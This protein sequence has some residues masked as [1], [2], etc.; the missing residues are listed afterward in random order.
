LKGP[1]TLTANAKLGS[2]VHLNVTGRYDNS[3]STKVPILQLSSTDPIV[4]LIV[5]VPI[6]IFPKITIFVGASG[7]VTAGFS[8][9]VTDSA[10][11]TAGISYINGQVTPTLTATNNFRTDPFGIDGGFSVKAFGG[12]TLELD[13]DGVLSPQ[14]SPDAFLNLDVTPTQTP[15][16]ILTGGLEGDGDV[17]LGIFGVNLADFNFPNLLDYPV[18]PATIAQASSG[19]ATADAAPTLNMIQPATTPLGSPDLT[20]ELSGAN[21]VPGATVSFNG[22]TL[23][24][25]FKDPNDLSAT[26]GSAALATAGTFP[27]SVTN[28]DTPGATSSSLNFTV[29]TSINNPV[30]SIASLSPNSAAV[31]SSAETLV[32]NG[33][34]FLST[35]TVTY[36][37][38]SHTPTYVSASQLTIALSA[39]DLAVAGSYP[40]VVTNPGPGGGASNAVGFAVGNP[41]PTISSLSPGSAAA[42]SP[43]QT[44]TI[45]GSNFLSSSVVAFNGS[46]R[47]TTFVSSNQ[48]TIALTTADLATAGS[49]PVSVTNPSPG[50]GTSNV[51]DFT[52][53]SGTTGSVTL[54]PTTATVPEGGAQTFTA[55]VAGSADGVTW[56]IQEGTN[57]GG[58]V[59]PTTPS[60]V[61]LPPS[62]TGT[63][64]IVATNVDDSSQTA[65][66]TVT[67]VPPLTLTILHQFQSSQGDGYDPLGRLVQASDGNFYGTTS[68]GGTSNSGT[69]FKVDS[70]GN[71]TTLHSFNGT[72][73]GI[74]ESGLIQDTDGNFYSTTFYGGAFGAGEVFKMDSAG[75]VSVFASFTEPGPI[76]PY[77][78][79]IQAS[80][81]YFYGT[82][83]YGGPTNAG[84]AF[85]VDSSGNVTLLHSFSSPEGAPPWAGVIQASDGNFW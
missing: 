68:G 19:F 28:P 4:V 59:N 18:P 70:A 54:S 72:D 33:Q 24:T 40:V 2:N 42:G 23:P 83:F 45:N 32:I 76:N 13:I 3:F 78:A 47:A 58:I 35:S 12:A 22:V 60:V 20:L 9:G 14:F 66:A 38:L 69:L 29:S 71:F 30:P 52:V 26:V 31:G 10:T 8:T 15:W 5:D 61:Y 84:T 85:K 1:H 25:T 21:F 49:F 75:N 43:A 80:D 77:A 6:V 39:S 79:L 27:V 65:V 37:G 81:G 62:A 34:N 57:S 56:S 46:S 73:G 16:W 51:V 64:H 55:S 82:T 53:A 17:A 11:A 48:L 44:L 63:F 41:V 74:P 36:N 67:V 50:G 7:A